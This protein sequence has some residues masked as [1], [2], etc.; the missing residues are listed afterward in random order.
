MTAEGGAGEA[1]ESGERQEPLPAG[2]ST[3]KNG[4]PVQG[5]S[6][7]GCPPVWAVA[8]IGADGFTNL[9]NISLGPASSPVLSESP[10]PVGVWAQWRDA[11]RGVA[12]SASP[13]GGGQRGCGESCVGSRRALSRSD[14]QGDPGKL[15]PSVQSTALCPP[16]CCPPTSDLFSGTWGAY[17]FLLPVTRGA[18][19]VA[20]PGRCLGLAWGQGSSMGPGQG[21]PAA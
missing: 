17:A 11:G 2:P 21:R 14:S 5:G 15:G 7:A 10:V 3:F 16:C 8:V 12:C 19:A 13:L 18:R 1:G 9:S 4:S 6:C 20:W